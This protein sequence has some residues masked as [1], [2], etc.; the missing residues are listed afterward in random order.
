MVEVL[1]D[2]QAPSVF[3]HGM[4]GTI[5]PIATAHGEGRARF[6]AATTTSQAIAA[7]QLLS[8]RL[9]SVRYVDNYLKPTE[10]YPANPNGVSRFFVTP[11]LLTFPIQTQTETQ[12]PPSLVPF[13]NF[14]VSFSS[15]TSIATSSLKLIPKSTYRAPPV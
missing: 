2:P 8:D 3:L 6:D 5:M 4:A 11:Y 13:H 1:D 15:R 7:Q 12:A 14:L 10:R 9:L